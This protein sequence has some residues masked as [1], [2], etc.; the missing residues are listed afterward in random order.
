MRFIKKR[1]SFV[2]LLG[3]AFTSLFFYSSLTT[4]HNAYAY[5]LDG[6]V[7]GIEDYSGNGCNDLLYNSTNDN[8]YSN[9]DIEVTTGLG[10]KTLHCGSGR[11]N[12]YSST[13]FS[14]GCRNWQ[15]MPAYTPGFMYYIDE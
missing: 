12:G 10:C 5:E 9:Y 1:M 7:L 8:C 13:Y 3:L 6:T 15:T 11:E 2:L 14:S 4:T